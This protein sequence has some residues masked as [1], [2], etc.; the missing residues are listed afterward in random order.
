MIP[1]VNIYDIEV[2][3]F[4]SIHHAVETILSRHL[5]DSTIAVAINPEKILKSI[6][7]ILTKE[8]IDF[9]T[10]RYL[11]GMGTVK[12][13][14][15]KLKKKISRIPGCELWEELMM[16]SVAEN[17]P[18]F[19]LGA[20]SEIL[21]KTVCILKNK[22]VNVVGAKDGYFKDE[23]LLIEDIRKS[24]AR[25]LTVAMGSPMQELFMKK[26]KEK[27]LTCFM[28]GV[29]GTYNVYTGQVKRAPKIWC[30]MNLEWLYRLI[31]EPSRIFRQIK[32]LK[33]IQLAALN[34]L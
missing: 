28:M 23:D 17:I 11:D 31:L 10:I 7:C 33:F 8:A 14:S 29:G 16:A 6:D 1:K 22:G 20:S 3:C 2:S 13:A 27:G 12:V 26:C 5:L 15:L 34:K 32:L 18:V 30:Q 24:N 4:D 21:E 25:I 9:A 19:I